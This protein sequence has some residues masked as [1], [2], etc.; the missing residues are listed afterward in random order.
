M[1]TKKGQFR[2]AGEPNNTST[3]NNYPANLTFDKLVSGAWL[4]DSNAQF[5]NLKILGPQGIGFYLN[6]TPTPI[7][8]NENINTTHHVS[9]W[10]LTNEIG[11]ICPVYDIKFDAK[12]L[13]KFVDANTNHRIYLIIDYEQEG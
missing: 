7:Y 5:T 6:N 10:E 11:T 13:R 2:Y 8:L 1:A 4:A 9:S 12:S 3:P